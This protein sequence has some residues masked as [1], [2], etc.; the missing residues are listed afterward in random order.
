MGSLAPQ[1]I[2]QLKVC[3]L[4]AAAIAAAAPPAARAALTGVPAVTVAYIVGWI[5]DAALAGESLSSVR[6]RCRL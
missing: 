6:T 2:L 3:C 4:D 5:V 1:H